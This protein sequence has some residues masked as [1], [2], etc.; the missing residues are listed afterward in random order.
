[1]AGFFFGFV[2][3]VILFC[4]N[5]RKKCCESIVLNYKIWY[6]D[7]GTLRIIRVFADFR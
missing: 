4:G 2:Q 5:N 1:M 7:Y 6:N 3:F